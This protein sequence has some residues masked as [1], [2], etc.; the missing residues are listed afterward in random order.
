MKIKTKLSK[1]ITNIRIR[2]DLH[3]WGHR[4]KDLIKSIKKNNYYLH[5]DIMKLTQILAKKKLL[6]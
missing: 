5:L 4:E 6:M 3:S 2:I 1:K